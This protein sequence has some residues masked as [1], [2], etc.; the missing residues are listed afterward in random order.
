M[1]EWESRNVG[2]GGFVEEITGLGLGGW[3]KVC[4]GNI[5]GMSVPGS[6]DSPGGIKSMALSGY[7]EAFSRAEAWGLRKTKVDVGREW[8]QLLAKR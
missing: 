8:A 7:Y 4:Q 5:E 6:M 3:L 1:N 2:E